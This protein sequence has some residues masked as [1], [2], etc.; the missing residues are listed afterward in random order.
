MYLCRSLQNFDIGGS[1][2]RMPFPVI[3]AFGFVKKAAALVNTKRKFLD[4]KLGKAIVSAANEVIEGKLQDHFPLVVWY[5]ANIW[6]K[7]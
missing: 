6:K 5:E 3:Q 2:E 4:E 1:Q 7:R